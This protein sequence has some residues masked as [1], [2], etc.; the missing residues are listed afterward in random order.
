MWNGSC[1]RE[2]TESSREVE[3]GFLGVEKSL[4]RGQI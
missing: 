4:S 3:N 2:A 1:S